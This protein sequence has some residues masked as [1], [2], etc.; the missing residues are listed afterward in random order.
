MELDRIKVVFNCNKKTN[1]KVIDRLSRIYTYI[2]IDEVQDLAGYDL[3]LLN[4]FF[5]CNSATLLVGDLRQGTYSTNST[6]K[7]KKYKKS[8]IVGFFE[9]NKAKLKLIVLP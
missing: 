9:K 1:G 2:F 7:N 4:L 3:E 6:S 5:K 8:K